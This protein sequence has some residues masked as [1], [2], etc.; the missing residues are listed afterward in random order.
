MYVC[1]L[2]I[3]ISASRY[4]TTMYQLHMPSGQRVLLLPLNLLTYI[5]FELF[6][7]FRHSHFLCTYF[8]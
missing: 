4:D 5:D 8:L 3:H 6:M 2:I 7:L 1:T